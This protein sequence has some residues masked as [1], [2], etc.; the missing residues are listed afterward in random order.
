MTV[1]NFSPQIHQQH[2]F[3]RG[4]EKAKQYVV[5]EKL[6][7]RAPLPLP[8]SVTLAQ[9]IQTL[10]KDVFT[11]NMR[12]AWQQ[13]VITYSAVALSMYLIHLAPWYLL[14]LAWVLSGTA[15]T[16]LFVV[17][18]EC[19]HMSFARQRWLND[20]VGIVS[21]VPSLY[22][23]ESWRIQH[24]HHHANTNKLHVDNAWQPFQRD[25]WLSAGPIEKAIMRQV[26]G[27]FYW[28][29]SIG[30]QIKEHFFLSSFTPEQ[31]PRVKFSLA[32][33]YLFA[34]VFFPTMLYNVGVW[35]LIKFWLMPFIG[36]HFWMSSF[37]LI[38][39]TLPHLPF[40]PESE[41]TDAQARLALTVHCEFPAWVEFLCHHINVHVPHHVST[42]IPAYNLRAA[43]RALLDQWGPYMTSVEFSWAM[44][45]DI[46][47]K[48]HIYDEDVAYVPFEHIEQPKSTKSFER[49]PSPKL[50]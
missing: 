29:A 42:S 4:A 13:V 9:V 39:H 11:K 43:H 24:N 44:L 40:L 1:S 14:P 32:C 3:S 23:F 6:Y 8:K 17:G 31:R 10:P 41:W 49:P 36:Y 28:L 33:V 46:T 38:H 34:A 27:S 30:H 35:G 21:F 48:C 18:H 7:G 45:R 37:T 15:C 19:G 25:Y 5:N 47:T 26:K 12:K 20:L 50:D 22:P 16:G 2:R